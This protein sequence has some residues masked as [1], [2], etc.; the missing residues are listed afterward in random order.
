MSESI[1]VNPT[2]VD[3]IEFYVS[4]DGTYTGMSQVGLAKLCGVA[5]STMRNT[6]SKVGGS[7]TTS[8]IL[9]NLTPRVSWV[10]ASASNNA[11]VV[12]SD[13][14]AGIIEYYAF[15]SKAANDTAKFAFRKFAKKGI[16]IWIKELTGYATASQSETIMPQLL[17]TLQQVLTEVTELKETTQA[18]KTM[19]GI[20]T[21]VFPNLDNMLT[22]LEV[23]DE[24]LDDEPDVTEM[25]ATEWLAKNDITLGTT[26]K[27]QF[28]LLLSET[29]KTVTGKDPKTV[30]KRGKNGKWNNG[31][32]VY[33]F[34]E[35]PILQLCLNKLLVKELN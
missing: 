33:H 2:T 30:N 8:E 22:K 32:S 23:E 6:L 25:T 3:E 27:R 10:R 26:K 24:L 1:V 11:E 34:T 20:T 7:L 31:V 14:C 17:S 9:Q 18:Y 16:D 12:P 4:N 13:V 21:K 35:Y 19:R 28:S 5:E 15:E 29:Y